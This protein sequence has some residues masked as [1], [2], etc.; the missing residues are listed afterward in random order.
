MLVLVYWVY[1]GVL[2]QRGCE[3]GGGR[4]SD[5]ST[6]PPLNH[7]STQLHGNGTSL[8]ST[9]NCGP[10]CIRL[11]STGFDTGIYQESGWP[12]KQDDLTETM[13]QEK[14]TQERMTRKRE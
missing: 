2:C 7:S 3:G 9:G 4:L 8:F 14:I 6:Q 1:V 5:S 12:K 13:I 11:G 10:H